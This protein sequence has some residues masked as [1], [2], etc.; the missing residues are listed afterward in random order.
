MRSKTT[1]RARKRNPTMICGV[2]FLIC[3]ECGRD[4][5]VAELVIRECEHAVCLTCWSEAACV[6]C[7]PARRR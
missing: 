3:I 4:R 7:P 6:G 2:D 1:S 5:F